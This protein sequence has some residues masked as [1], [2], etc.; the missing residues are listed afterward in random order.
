MNNKQKKRLGVV[1]IMSTTFLLLLWLFGSV[2]SFAPEKMSITYTETG[3][4]AVGIAVERARRYNT[5]EKIFDPIGA[6][7]T[8][9][10]TVKSCFT[11]KNGE[12]MFYMTQK[13]EK[14][15]VSTTEKRRLTVKIK[16]KEFQFEPDVKQPD[17]IKWDYDIWFEDGKVETNR[18]G[19]LPQEVHLEEKEEEIER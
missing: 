10:I 18:W 5:I 8:P 16:G 1:I 14:Y 7:Y 4:S 3:E 19:R 13:H 17:A 9:I 15:R 2:S 11:D 6:T 12:A